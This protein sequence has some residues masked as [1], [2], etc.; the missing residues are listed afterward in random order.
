MKSILVDALRQA[1]DDDADQALTDSGSFDASQDALDASA[2][3]AIE[4]DHGELEL[5]STSNALVVRDESEDVPDE[6]VA[7]DEDERVSQ[8][9]AVEYEPVDDDHAV[10]VAG[11]IPLPVTKRQSPRLARLAPF[12][13]TALAIAVATS[14]LWI[15]KLGLPGTTL[16]TTISQAH[17]ADPADVK[18]SDLEPTTRFPFLKNGQPDDADGS[19][20]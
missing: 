1:E 4:E 2:N 12:L 16:G 5:M 14:W 7:V 10:T 11:M 19:M 18:A 15:N 9:F 3:D 8:D 6:P 13:C 20:Q 17:A